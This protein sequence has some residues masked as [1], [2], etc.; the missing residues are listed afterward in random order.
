MPTATVAPRSS[1]AGAEA[2]PGASTDRANRMVTAVIWLFASFVGV[3]G[4]SEKSGDLKVAAFLLSSVTSSTRRP[5]KNRNSS[6][7]EKEIGE[8]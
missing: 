2:L 4:T 5:G 8:E 6:C 1:G 7:P 3:A